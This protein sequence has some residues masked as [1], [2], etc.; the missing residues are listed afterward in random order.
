MTKT[1]L[2]S[3]FG[4]EEP[5]RDGCIE[6]IRTIEMA[7][8]GNSRQGIKEATTVGHRFTCLVSLSHI[9]LVLCTHTHTY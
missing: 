5:G 1:D 6:E 2:G 3:F 8:S 9:A 7:W 4:C